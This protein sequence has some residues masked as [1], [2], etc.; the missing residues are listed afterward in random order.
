LDD[1]VIQPYSRAQGVIFVPT[2]EMQPNL[3]VNII[4]KETNEKIEFTFTNIK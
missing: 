1:I 4:D 2:S 3:T